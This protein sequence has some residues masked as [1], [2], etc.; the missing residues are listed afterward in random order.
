LNWTNASL[1]NS[2]ATKIL[3]VTAMNNTMIFWCWLKTKRTLSKT[4]WALWKPTS[5]H[6]DRKPPLN[7]SIMLPLLAVKASMIFAKNSRD[8][9]NRRVSITIRWD[10][11]FFTPT[12][13]LFLNSFLLRI[14]R[15]G[16]KT[17]KSKTLIRII[18]WSNSAYLASM[19]SE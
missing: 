8:T 11:W 4:S 6:G 10:S 7:G 18:K 14:L 19:T 15:N 1:L 9:L 16:Y 5:S 13:E 2:K 3:T 12:M 17:V